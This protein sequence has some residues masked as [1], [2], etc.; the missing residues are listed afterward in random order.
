MSGSRIRAALWALVAIGLSSS[1]VLAAEGEIAAIRQ[2]LLELAGRLDAL[3]QQ[4]SALRTENEA[5]KAAPAGDVQAQLAKQ[6]ADLERLKGAEWASRISARGDLRYRHEQIADDLSNSTDSNDK[7]YRDRLRARIGFDARVS[8]TLSGTFML[9][10]SPDDPRS[11]NQT[12]TGVNSRKS[13]GIDLAYVDWKYAAWGTLTAG[14]MRYPIVR[15]GQSLLQDGDINPEGLALTFREGI[16]FGSAYHLWIEERST[17][18]DTVIY[19]GQAGARLPFQGGTLLLSAQYSDLVKGEGFRPFYGCT[20]TAA[21][22]A[23]TIACANGNTVLGTTTANAVLANDFNVLGLSGEFNTRWGALPLQVWGDYA[24]NLAADDLDT[25]WSAGVVLGRAADRGTWEAGL[26][27]ESLGKDSLF[28]Q[29]VDSDFGDGRTDADGWILRGGYSLARNW[30][31]NA[32][33][34]LNE[35]QTEVGTSSDYR[36]LMLDLNLRF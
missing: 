5:L 7:R 16:W 21:V 13:V 9:A 27:F 18:A 28:G 11:S 31:V 1:P 36:R 24:R 6:S 22:A 29:L 34:F 35:R 19:G 8:D 4:N 30:L 32:T 14:K 2:Q 26:A 25:A 23:G 15:P 12:L 20:G 10:S 3:E 33:Y 17:A